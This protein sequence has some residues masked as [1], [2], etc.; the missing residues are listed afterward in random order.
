MVLLSQHGWP[1][2]QIAALLGYDPS[3]VWRWVQRYHHDGTR[4]LAD[5]P[6]TGRPRLGNPRP[7]R[8]WR[9]RP[10]K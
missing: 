8:R 9:G 2:S 5:R 6:R 1:A 4:G 10:H 3:T 7:G